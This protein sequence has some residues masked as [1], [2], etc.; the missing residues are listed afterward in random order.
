MMP[1]HMELSRLVNVS[2]PA[3]FGVEWTDAEGN[4][5]QLVN[6]VGTTG[7]QWGRKPPGGTHWW[8]GSVTDPDRF[9]LTTA[10]VKFSDFRGICERYVRELYLA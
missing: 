10:P 8:S 6:P 5:Y 1:D 2:N 7:L 4:V 9:G 3:A